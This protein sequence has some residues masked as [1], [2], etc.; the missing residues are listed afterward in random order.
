MPTLWDDIYSVKRYCSIVKQKHCNKTG[1]MHLSPILRTKAAIIG[2][3]LNGND[4]QQLKTVKFHDKTWS[5]SWKCS[6]YRRKEI[7]LG[8]NVRVFAWRGGIYDAVS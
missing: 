8:M 5:E 2:A 3:Y 7:R 6:S 4:F 1:Q